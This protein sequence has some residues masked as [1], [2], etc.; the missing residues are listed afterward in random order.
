MNRA[1]RSSLGAL[2]LAAPC[3]AQTAPI[4]PFVGAYSD[5]FESQALQGGVVCIQ[6]RVLGARADLCCPFGSACW[7][8]SG[9]GSSAA[10]APRSG[11]QLFHADVAVELV[12]DRPVQ[13]FGAWFASDWVGAGAVSFLDAA[14]QT[15]GS[16]TFQM[17]PCIAGCSW[18]WNGWTAGAGPP[19]W[20]LRF[21][22]A[23]ATG[24]H[25]QLDDLQVDFA[26]GFASTYCTSKVN[27]Q[28]CTPAISW[29]GA[30]SASAGSGFT[31]DA[32]AVLNQKSGVL[33]Y[34]TSGRAVLPFHSGFL[35]LAPPRRRTAVQDS[36]GSASGADCSGVYSLDFNAW[37]ASGVDPALV[38]GAEVNAQYWSRDPGFPP[39]GAIGLTDA[40]EFRVCP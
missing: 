10:I 30:A 31:L 16:A 4:A 7:I 17:D 33:F 28:G 14:G 25:F 32:S 24:G 8:A 3:L 39:P 22:T 2:L 11:A 21:D 18:K 15:I 9:S 19:I 23:T 13:R 1:I 20:R 34:G 6:E 27:S 26:C 29:S 36:G 35:C 12:F 40:V 38:A 5:D 37:I